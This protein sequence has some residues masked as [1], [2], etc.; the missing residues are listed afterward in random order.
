MISTPY[1][2]DAISL[3]SIKAEKTGQRHKVVYASDEFGG[4]WKILHANPWESPDVYVEPD[5]TIAKK[6]EVESR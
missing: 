1:L 4:G 6:S 3:A 2:S 5:G